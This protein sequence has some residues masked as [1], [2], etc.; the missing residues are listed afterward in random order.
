MAKLTPKEELMDLVC[1]KMRDDEFW[2]W[3]KGW[4]DAELVI[5]I[6]EGWEDEE[7]INDSIADIKAIINK[8]KL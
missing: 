1:E 2:S 6:I 8:R 5:D 3:V 7:D 4:L